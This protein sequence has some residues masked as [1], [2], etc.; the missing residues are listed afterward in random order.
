MRL[1]NLGQIETVIDVLVW[2]QICIWGTELNF[3]LDLKTLPMG[4]NNKFTELDKIRSLASVTALNE[5]NS[6]QQGSSPE[7]VFNIQLQQF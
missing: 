3:E 6:K 7:S 1:N 2:K 5:S 4:L